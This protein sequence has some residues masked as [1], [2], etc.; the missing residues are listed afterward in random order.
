MIKRFH[1]N[2]N[3][4]HI[5]LISI[6]ILAWYFNYAYPLIWDDYVYSYVFNEHSFLK[7][8]PFDTQRI[9]GLKDIFLSQYNHYFSW[10]GRLVAHSIAQLFLWIG[11]EIFNVFNALIFI[12]IILEILW[13]SNKGKINFEFLF[14]DVLWVFSTFWIFSAF[15]S[16]CYTW[17]TLSCN[18][19]WTTAILLL[20]ILFYVHIYFLPETK[21]VIADNLPFNF[22]LFLFGVVAGCTNENTVCFVIII[23]SFF[24]YTVKC[25]NNQHDN[26]GMIMRPMVFGLVGLTAGYLLLMLAPGNYNRYT[27]MLNDG[28]LDTGAVL[29]GKNL[30]TFG[31]VVFIRFFLYYYVLSRL[32]FMKKEYS[33]LDSEEQK[34]FN[35]ATAF[36]VLSILSLVVMIISPEFR[37]RSTFPS[38]IFALITAALLRNQGLKSVKKSCVNHVIGFKANKLLNFIM[39]FYVSVTLSSTVFMYTMIKQQ[40]DI[41]MK[42]IFDE[43]LSQAGNVVVVEEVPKLIEDNFELCFLSSGGHLPNVYTLTNNEQFWINKDIALYYGI[44]AIR[45]K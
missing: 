29:I 8:L 28:T 30:K 32:W 18:Y 40:N 3:R 23:L 19:L 14:S 2:T 37:M 36:A 34:V 16:D 9:K 20:F 44:K 35:V 31:I 45:G 4:V 5:L 33:V 24:V 41:M 7:S 42:Q 15:L 1:K 27:L 38:L 11:K 25:N 12:L 13:I 43:K 21:L 6:F 22:L 17:L 10:G 39:Y 26:Y